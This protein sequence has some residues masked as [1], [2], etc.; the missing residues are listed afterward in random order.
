MP[1]YARFFVSSVILASI[2]VPVAADA[3]PQA[4][5]R[6]DTAPQGTAGPDSRHF[7]LSEVDAHVSIVQWDRQ[8]MRNAA[9]RGTRFTVTRFP[10]LA[11]GVVN[12]DL[13]PFHVAGADTQFVVGRRGQP[14]RPIAFDPTSIMLFRGDVTGLS[15]SHVF[16]ALGENLA[17]GFVDLGP[18]R[19]RYQISTK[20]GQGQPLEAGEI[21]V[22]EP[23][24]ATNLPPGVPLCGVEGNHLLPGTGTR[25]IELPPITDTTARIVTPTIGLKH[26]ELAIET[27]YEYFIL[28]ADELEA[29]SYLIAM[30]GAV[31]DI[32][33]RDV[34]TRIEIVYTRIWDQPNDIINGP[35]PLSEFVDE[36]ETNQQ[37]IARDAAQFFSGRRDFPFGGQAFL[38]QLCNFAYGVVGYA[39]GFFPDPSRPSPF[40]W[41]VSVTAHELGHNAGTGHTHGGANPIDTCDNP[42]TTPQRGTIMSYCGQTW[43]GMN[44]NT[45]NYFHTQIQANIDAHVDVSSCIVD[46]CNM[47]DVSDADDISM[48]DSDDA[49]G[50]GIPDEC[51]DCNE[52]L[53]LDPTDISGGTS[54]DDNRNRI[55]DECEP[56]CNANGIPDDKDIADGTSDDA[57]GN[58]IPDEC[59]EDCNNNGTS[60]YNEIQANMPL[61][62]DRNA[63]LDSCQDCDNDLVPDH[64]ELGAAHYLWVTS[65]LSGSIIREFFA[66]TG[67]RTRASG[68]LGTAQ[69]N[70]GQ[71]LIIT[72]DDRTLVTS[73]GDNRVMEF[74][75]DGLYLG[76]FVSAF[77][78]CV[79]QVEPEASREPARVAVGRA[80]VV[81]ELAHRAE[82]RDTS[83]ACF[84]AGEG[85]EG[86]CDGLRIRVV[87]VVDDEHVTRQLHG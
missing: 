5:T 29:T 34:N 33:M 27:D 32:Y 10:L 7:R 53:I 38:S 44:A 80:G 57:Y 64:A 43:S 40:N 62:V 51:E 69:V 59:E 70:Q 30:Y 48:G 67:V 25:G 21:S 37:A 82:H 16:L 14:D 68:G 22:F 81:A 20:D 83:A 60:D 87:A 56:D 74:S 36:W 6:P 19:A 86:V 55:P 85:L 45:D 23:V 12:L 4:A 65:G 13:Q 47:N 78:D 26:L 72:S 79:E 24:N 77:A 84:E 49:N 2:A 63:I 52:N 28:F 58:G 8:A 1:K 71:D 17:T 54:D 75:S 41:D 61:D 66:T 3:A 11:G 50:N 46:D 18:G 76:D 35:D 9:K 73:A 15:G 42:N 39:V 31:S